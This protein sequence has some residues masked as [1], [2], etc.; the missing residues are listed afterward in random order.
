[1]ALGRLKPAGG[2][3]PALA[4]GGCSTMAAPPRRLAVCAAALLA[5]LVAPGCGDGLG[6][7]YPVEGQV[8]LNGKP[9]Q[10]LSGSVVFVPDQTAGNGRPTGASGSL[11]A[12]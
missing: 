5:S 8:L 2:L 4:G 10:G 3:P 1:M 12:T 11:D 6:P 9:L 7:R